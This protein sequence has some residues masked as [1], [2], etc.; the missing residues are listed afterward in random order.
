[1]VYKINHKYDEESETCDLL[2]IENIVKLVNQQLCSRMDQ[3]QKSIVDLKE[4]LEIEKQLLEDELEQGKV[5]AENLQKQYDIDMMSMMSANMGDG[6]YCSNYSTE[7]Y[8]DTVN[9]QKQ[10]PLVNFREKLL[11]IESKS[12]IELIKIKQN[13]QYFQPLEQIVYYDNKI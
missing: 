9:L 6:D 7:E 2:L 5:A 4:Q 11:E 8:N 3:L 1:M 13:L 12:N 10:R